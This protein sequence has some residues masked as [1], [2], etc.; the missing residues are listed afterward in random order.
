MSEI[1]VSGPAEF[2][3]PIPVIVVLAPDP[4]LVHESRP[5]AAG[6]P[7]ILLLYPSVAEFQEPLV[8]DPRD[9]RR[10]VGRS[11]GE[12]N[13]DDISNREKKTKSINNDRKKK[14]IY[15]LILKKTMCRT[16]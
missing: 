4:V 15:I 5:N 1:V 14:K 9:Q 16:V 10:P 11:C 7:D 2:R 6:R 13:T 3:A 8:R 12:K